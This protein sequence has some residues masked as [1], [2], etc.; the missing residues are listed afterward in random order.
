MM[1]PVRY[2]L[3]L[4]M[5]SNDHALPC[6]V[7]WRLKMPTTS[8]IK[9]GFSNNNGNTELIEP[10]NNAATGCFN[11]KIACH[12][13]NTTDK[14]CALFFSANAFA[15]FWHTS[16]FFTL[17]LCCNSG[18][19]N[20]RILNN[21]QKKIIKIIIGYIFLSSNDDWAAVLLRCLLRHINVD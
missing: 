2:N 8:I 3:C 9:H 4:L 1:T 19:D 14:I 13:L 18:P 6:P 7:N 10:N 12:N 17:S 5:F 16:I 21:G 11:I 15:F 20:E